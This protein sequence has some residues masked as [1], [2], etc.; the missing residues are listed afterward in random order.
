VRAPLFIMHGDPDHVVPIRF[1]EKLF[2]A[3]NEPKE[4]LRM[5][6]AGHQALDDPRVQKWFVEWVNGVMKGVKPP[7]S[8]APRQSP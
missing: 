7:S 2:A 3:A 6:G 8:Q 4:F 5:P 1:G